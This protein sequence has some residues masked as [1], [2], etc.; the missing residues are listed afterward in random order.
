MQL[1]AEFYSATSATGRQ[2]HEGYVTAMATHGLETLA[3][4]V[5]ATV[6]A[7]RAAAGVMSRPGLSCGVRRGALNRR[8]EAQPRYC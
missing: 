8:P 5:P 7:A 2:R 4:A 6:E 1:P 3:Q